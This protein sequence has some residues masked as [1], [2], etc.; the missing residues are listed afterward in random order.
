VEPEKKVLIDATPTTPAPDVI[1]NICI[2]LTMSLTVAVCYFSC[3]VGSFEEKFV[4]CCQ[5]TMLT[6]S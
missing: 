3:S 4:T 1:F 6:L 2:F 5:D